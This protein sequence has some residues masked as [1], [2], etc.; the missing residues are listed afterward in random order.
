MAGTE[1]QCIAVAEQLGVDYKIKRIGLKFP[2]NYF[3]PLILKTAP[4][5]YITGIDWHSDMPDL[6]IAS[7]R[8]AVPVTLQFTDAFTVFIQNPKIKSSHFN[9]VAAPQHDDVKG[10]NIIR[11]V[12]APNRI[13]EKSLTQAKSEFD[14]SYLPEKKIA[15][16]IGGNSKTH[17]MPDNFGYGLFESLLPYMQSDDYGFMVTVSRRTPDHIA[18]HIR[19]LFNGSQC[20]IWDEHGRNPYHAYLSHA[21]YILVTE[22]STSMLSD[23]LTTGKPTYRLKL[24]GSSEKFDRLYQNLKRR[25][26]LNIFEGELEDINYKPLQDAKMVADNIKKRFEEFTLSR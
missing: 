11:T 8:K 18:D 23:A 21:D 25:A 22:D 1:N 26:K 4:R 20:E 9:V 14:F 12:A 2:F 6:I 16:L 19:E 7:G 5:S 24:N 10:N 15:I 13:T 17:S 3:C